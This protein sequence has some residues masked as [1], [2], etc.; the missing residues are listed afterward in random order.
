MN[1]PN[2]GIFFFILI[3][4][5]TFVPSKGLNSFMQA[6][7]IY[8]RL[9]SVR[10]WVSLLLLGL[11]LYG[12]VF[13]WRLYVFHL[14]PAEELPMYGSKVKH[15]DDT[16]RVAFIGDS[17]AEYHTT[18]RCDTIFV[19]KAKLFTDK[20]VKCTN[21]GKGGAMSKEIYYYMFSSM[22]VESPTEPDRCTQPLIEAH[23]DYCVVMAGINDCIFQRPLNYFK[24][25]Y[26]LILRLL[27][28]NGIRPVVMQMPRVNDVMA[29]DYKPWHKRTPYHIRAW[30]LGTRSYR[31]PKYREALVEMLNETGLKDSVLYIPADKWGKGGWQDRSIFSWDAIHLHLQ[32]YEVL[33]SCIASEIIKDWNLRNGKEN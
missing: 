23:P 28:H 16:L 1:L 8:D 7:K 27:L 6:E 9:S 18:L 4:F 5:C 12:G 25:N 31:V 22:T 2:V 29:I 21:R 26:R 10:F 15:N 11:A 3:F 32:G 20:P 19:K 13:L 33:D 30:L 24:Q 14:V 17:W